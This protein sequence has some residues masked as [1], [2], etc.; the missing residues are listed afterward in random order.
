MVTDVNGVEEDKPTNCPVPKPGKGSN[1]LPTTSPPLVVAV[2]APGAMAKVLISMP[3]AETGPP[4]EK[5]I[6]SPAA[7][8][9]VGVLPNELGSVELRKADVTMEIPLLDE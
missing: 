7:K 4:K 9:S 3:K 2:Y 6:V 1:P 8:N 5:V